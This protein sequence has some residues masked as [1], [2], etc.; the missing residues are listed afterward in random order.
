VQGISALSVNKGVKE[1]NVLKTD[2]EA[3]AN[4]A[5]YYAEKDR[6]AC[7]LEFYYQMGDASQ[8]RLAKTHATQAKKYWEQLSDVTEK[9]YRPLL[10]PLRML[11]EDFTFRSELPRL[12]ADLDRIAQIEK[13]IEK[14]MTARSGHSFQKA[15]P[16]QDLKTLPDR[17]GPVVAWRQSA[18][19]ANREQGWMH[20]ECTVYDTSGV[21]KVKLE[22]KP[23]P[24]MQKWQ[25]P[26]IMTRQGDVFSADVPLTYEGLLYSVVAIDSVGNV[27]RFPDV[28]KET[29]YVAV[30]PWD[31]G[32]EPEL[33]ITSEAKISGGL[34][35]KVVRWQDVSTMGRPGRF[36]QYSGKG[37]QVEFSFSVNE[38]SDYILTLAKVVNPNSGMAAVYVD[39]REIGV[40]D[41]QQD[42]GGDIPVKQ[43]IRISRLKP[44][45]H[46][47][48][49]R[50]LTDKPVAIEGFGL[51]PT[52][53]IID[54]FLISQSF[55][56]WPKEITED[57]YPIGKP[58]IQWKPAQVDDK[59]IVHLDG[60]LK[61]NEN[62]RAFAV[63]EIVCKRPQKTHL[64]IGSND[65]AIVWLN[66][67]RISSYPKKRPFKYNQDRIPVQL[68]KGKNTLV[69]L[70][71]QA[72][73]F[74]LF[75]A[76]IETYD[77][78]LELPEL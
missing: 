71:F 2:I 46:S 47:L 70:V 60:Q 69:L 25:K 31:R 61:P 58:G 17:Q 67:K 23:L 20:I 35:E 51:A 59:G 27:T 13:E 73:R 53:A 38:L 55:P 40:M 29:P 33:R 62:C 6:A 8:V 24:S 9:Q 75:N 57:D 15:P 37:G 21:D 50:L 76:N 19:R 43:E 41:C 10:E 32:L 77:F 3:L 78:R 64:L 48:R 22:W 54:R 72:G 42:V 5:H 12:Q 30:N 65:G 34:Q 56:G 14:G 39:G 63:T 49:F 74:W 1:W 36:R 7:S 52:P 28:R 18:I 44:G 68:Q 66:G 11:M 4:L 16:G 26:I 45:T